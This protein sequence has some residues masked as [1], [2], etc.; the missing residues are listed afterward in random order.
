MYVHTRFVNIKRWELS[1]TCAVRQSEGT[2]PLCGLNPKTLQDALTRKR[3]VA[4]L[5]G[6]QR[7]ST[8]DS[9]RELLK[10]TK[11][12]PTPE[13]PTQRLWGESPVLL[14]SRIPTVPPTDNQGFNHSYRMLSFMEKGDKNMTIHSYLLVFSERNTKNLDKKD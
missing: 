14:S 2:G 5:W 6:R 11:V 8:R 9:P 10:L 12:G 7:P 4:V 1:A 13:V 3:W